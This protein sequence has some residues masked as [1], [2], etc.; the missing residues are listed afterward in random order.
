MDAH[1]LDH[2]RAE[3]LLRQVADH[4]TELQDDGLREGGLAKIHCNRRLDR[5]VRV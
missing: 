2:I 5:L 3:F 1:L 4:A